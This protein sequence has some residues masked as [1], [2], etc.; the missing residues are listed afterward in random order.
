MFTCNH[1]YISQIPYIISQFLTFV[2]HMEASE[3]KWVNSIPNIIEV[4]SFKLEDLHTSFLF[5][6]CFEMRFTNLS[7]T[8]LHYQNLFNNLKYKLIKIRTEYQKHISLFNFD[9]KYDKINLESKFIK[10]QNSYASHIV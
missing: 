6:V 5:R 10:F 7:R 4:N 1:G 3:P 8:V 2:N 9:L